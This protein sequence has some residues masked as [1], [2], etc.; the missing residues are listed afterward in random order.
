M[1]KKIGT[2]LDEELILEAKKAALSERQALSHFLSNA[3]RDYLHAL[4]KKKN[5]VYANACGRTKG[6]MSVPLD[7]LRTIMEEG[8]VHEDR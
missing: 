7:I 1:K 3:L 8:R 5:A 6:V 4:N 2:M